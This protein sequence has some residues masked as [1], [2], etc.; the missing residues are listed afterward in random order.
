MAQ[1]VA[2]RDTQVDQVE[3]EIEEECLEAL[4][5]YQRVATDLWLETRCHAPLGFRWNPFCRPCLHLLL[6]ERMRAGRLAVIAAC[7]RTFAFSY[8]ERTAANG[9]HG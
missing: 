1:S 4:A 7:V 5:I 6:S 3:V 9:S 2:A 8:H